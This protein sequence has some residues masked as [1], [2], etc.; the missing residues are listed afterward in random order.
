[1]RHVEE[2][3]FKRAN[4]HIGALDQGRDFVEQG[5]I[6]NRFHTPADFGGC[7]GE[8]TGNLSTA[9]GE[10]GDDCTIFGE[11]L[12]VHIRVRQHDGRHTGFKAVA[13]CAVASGQ[14]QGFDGHDGAAVQ[15]HQAVRRAHKVD[16]APAG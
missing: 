12:C 6:V 16:A 10:A 3:F 7:G 5:R 2:L 11:R 1:M 14:A 4:Q 9:L 8:L 15:C 13:L